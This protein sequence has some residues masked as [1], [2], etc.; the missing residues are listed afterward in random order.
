MPNNRPDQIR[1]KLFEEYEDSLFK[2]VMH[3]AAERE[4]K[5]FLEEKEKLKN[6]PEFAPS[7]EAIQKFSR[8]LDTRLKKSQTYATRQQMLKILNKA[9]VAILIML[10]IMFTTVTSVQAL[11]VKV[12]NYL[13]D[14]QQ[15]YT[16]FELKENEN[17]LNGENPVVNWTKDY[18]PT[19]IPDGYKA[20][21]IS[22]SKIYNEIQFKNERG[23]FITYTEL[24]EGNRPALDTENASV[25]KTVDINGHE[26]TLVEKNSVVTII[27]EMNS[28]IF[29]IR[30]QINQDVAMKI[31]EGVKYIN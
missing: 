7:K 4:G 13:K 1:K 18:V 10:V 31:S 21:D 11:R 20:T 5:L 9:A 29:M 12:L 23:E 3:D 26:G 16:S 2:L 25:T 24:T 27:W 6:D 15:Q 19:Y 14:I 22:R 30:A 17:S 28:R 8:Q